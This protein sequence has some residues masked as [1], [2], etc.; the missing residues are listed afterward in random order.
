MTF[1]VIVAAIAIAI[2]VGVTQGAHTTEPRGLYA[3]E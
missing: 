2:V 1:I 3:R